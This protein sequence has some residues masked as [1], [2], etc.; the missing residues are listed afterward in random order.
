MTGLR[1]FPARC[2]LAV[3]GGA[4]A[5][6]AYPPLDVGWLVFP[7]LACLL[8]ALRGER[9]LRALAV[10]YLFGMS[11]FGIGL[12]W[13]AN[14]FGPM[15]L[16]LWCVL[17]M[18]PV[19]FALLHARAEAHG[20]CG[21]KLALFAA[22][23]WTAWEFV[24]GELF[25]LRFPWMTT[26]LA[27]SP[28]RLLPWVG[29]YGVGFLVMLAVAL[30]VFGWGT[31]RLAGHL[32]A[33][34]LLAG[35]LVSTIP[36]PPEAPGEGAISAAGIQL[37]G[38]SLGEFLA[39]T[40]ELPDDVR[41]VVW[42]EIAVPYD[43]RA[44]KRDWQQVLDLC[45]ERDITLTFGTKRTP[46]GPSG[47]WHNIALTVDADGVRGEHNKVH[48]VHMFDDGVAGTE[49]L[50][51]ATRFGRIGT[52]VC[53]DCDYQDV[54][55]RM[56][57]AGAETFMVPFLDAIPW[58]RKQH[59]Q[60]AELFQARACENGRW[61]FACGTSG[62]SQAIDPNGRVVSDL[63]FEEQGSFTGTVGKNDRLTFFTRAGWVG[64]WLALAAAAACTVRLLPPPRNFHRQG[65]GS[66]EP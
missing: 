40:R 63:G 33:L 46:A 41:Y 22:A 43:I 2:G 39:A 64:P 7:A 12:S 16:S 60:H 31:R 34:G 48:T 50:P 13:L 5:A 44:R 66:G 36:A 61:I 27:L 57:A 28:N 29:V 30:F 38:V 1:S 37:E 10:G 51:V 58:G 15:A 49:A 47:P 6:A 54:V 21:W 52:P 9:G 20:W 45:R 65:G 14:L 25:H 59:I 55:R 56:T 24:R 32:P 8:V 17:A 42:P 18:F 23:N 62:V 26:G 3:A 4:L 19:G 11:V 53:F 35:V